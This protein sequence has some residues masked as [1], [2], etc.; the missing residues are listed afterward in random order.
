MLA[1][2]GFLFSLLKWC[3]EVIYCCV[4][5]GFGDEIFIIFF[6]TGVEVSAEDIE[7]AAEKVFEENKSAIVEQRYRTNG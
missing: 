7:K 5:C 4:F 6:E 3:L 1:C 2:I